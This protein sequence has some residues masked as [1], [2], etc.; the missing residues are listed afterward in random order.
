MYSRL[1][2]RLVHFCILEVSLFIVPHS[3]VVGN[4]YGKEQDQR[5][6]RGKK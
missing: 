4:F 2:D 3:L 6:G 1:E 5:N